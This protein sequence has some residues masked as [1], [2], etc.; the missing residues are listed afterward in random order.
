MNLNIKDIDKARLNEL[1][2]EERDIALRILKQ[3]AD[4]GSSEILEE[5]VKSD[6]AETPVDIETFLRDK[7]Y[8]G[9]GLIDPDGR[10]TV[11]PF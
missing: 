3:Y 11:F 4:K 10:F 1:S 6:Y 9:N 5:I 8:L 7:N 2:P